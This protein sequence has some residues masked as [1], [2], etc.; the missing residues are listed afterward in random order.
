MEISLGRTKISK[1]KKKKRGKVR[2]GG[3][4]AFRGNRSNKKY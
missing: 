1:K 4:G 2:G 3:A